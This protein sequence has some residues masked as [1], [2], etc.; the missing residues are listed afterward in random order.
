[1]TRQ[2]TCIRILDYATNCL[3]RQIDKHTRSLSSESTTD[4]SSEE[5]SA[6]MDSNNAINHYGEYLDYL[7]S[8]G[9]RQFDIVAHR[10][11]SE[12]TLKLRHIALGQRKSISFPEKHPNWWKTSNVIFPQKVEPVNELQASLAD[13]SNSSEALSHPGDSDVGILSDEEAMS[14]ADK[15]SKALPIRGESFGTSGRQFDILLSEGI[16]HDLICLLG[17]QYSLSPTVFAENLLGAQYDH[18]RQLPEEDW[19]PISFTTTTQHSA[20]VI[21]HFRWL[22]PIQL[23]IEDFQVMSRQFDKPTHRTSYVERPW[24]HVHTKSND[25]N[26]ITSGALK[27]LV[28]FEE[29]VTSCIVDNVVVC[30]VLLVC[31][32]SYRL[33]TRK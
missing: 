1:M 21:K 19:D 23:S 13:D 26:N 14:W 33:L 10:P 30:T 6:V 5:M 15:V 8:L 16:D 3:L 12:R 31:R 18:L 29:V 22:R 2:L 25:V 11:E 32:N 20:P 17:Y 4:S 27:T 7:S 28:A 24:Y 9:L